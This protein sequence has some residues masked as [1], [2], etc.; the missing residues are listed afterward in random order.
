MPEERFQ[1]QKREITV[2]TPEQIQATKERI[3]EINT[4]LTQ[5]TVQY[6]IALAANTSSEV[7]LLYQKLTAEKLNLVKRLKDHK[8]V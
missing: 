5:T 3:T 2:L 6:Y 8:R 7:T 4:I 1:P